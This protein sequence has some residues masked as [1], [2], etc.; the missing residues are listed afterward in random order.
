M[1]EAGLFASPRISNAA[2]ARGPTIA[3]IQSHLPDDLLRSH[4][5]APASG[6]DKIEM[7][8]NSQNPMAIS[9][10]TQDDTTKCGHRSLLRK[11]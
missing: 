7:M 11:T 10:T 3:A 2:G 5:I 1:A 6:I 8:T 9:D 4:A